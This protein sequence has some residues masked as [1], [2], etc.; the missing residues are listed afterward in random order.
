M[1]VLSL[2]LQDLLSNTFHTKQTAGTHG[3]L[4]LQSIL[5]LSAQYLDP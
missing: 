5:G 4:Q 3:L 1:L 2:Q